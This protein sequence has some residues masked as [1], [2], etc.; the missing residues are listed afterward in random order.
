MTKSTHKL[1]RLVL[2]PAVR[3]ALFVLLCAGFGASAALA[4][5]RA[6]VTDSLS[7]TVSVI[8]TASASVIATVP[9]GSR[10]GAVAVTPNGNF[11]Y[12]VNQFGSTVSVISAATNTV[13]ANIAL[14]ASAREIAITPDGASAYA[15]GFSSITV[16]DTATNTVVNSI[17]MSSPFQLA[18]APTG[19][20]GYVTHNSSVNNGVTVINTTTNTV[21]TTIPIPIDVTISAAVTPNAQFLYVTG[22]SFTT[23]A[24]LAVVDTATNSVVSIVQMPGTLPQGVVITP[25]G[26]FAYVA[27]MAGGICCGGGVRGIS[28]VSV[29]DTATN[30]EV[31]RVDA[32]LSPSAVAITPDGAFVYVT[33]LSSPTVSVISTANNAL[34]AII[35]VA[36]VAQDVAIGTFV[37]PPPPP[38]D[39]DPIETLVDQLEALIAD[40]TLAPDQGAGL[41]DKLQEAIAKHEAGQTAA[42]CNQLTSL[43]NQVNAFIGNGT[44]TAAQ[45]QP[46][47]D[48]ANEIKSDFGC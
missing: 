20:L 16:I 25:D 35:P 29:V 44:L 6:Y 1:P 30:T 41:L 39:P 24:K 23:G 4:Q 9:V 5:T 7:D 37:P 19:N 22:L 28:T 31:A 8:D 43:I 13:V 46:L 15:V 36:S 14:A 10:P 26:A 34:V 27:N 12:V 33:D 18:L 11:A 40:G 45:G 42:A 21:V 17:P 32:G 2:C 48:L 47:I 3:V 38:P